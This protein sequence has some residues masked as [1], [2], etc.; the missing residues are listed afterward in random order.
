[1][2]GAEEAGGAGTV[3][4]PGDTVWKGGTENNSDIVRAGAGSGGM[5]P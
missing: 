5:T 2:I 4:D 3:D 1:M